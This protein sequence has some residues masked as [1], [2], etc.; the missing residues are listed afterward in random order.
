MVSAKETETEVIIEVAD[1]G[2][3]IAPDRLADITDPFARDQ[4][5]PYVTDAGWGLG[6]S[7]VKALKNSPFISIFLAALIVLC[8]F[9]CIVTCCFS[10][11]HCEQPQVACGCNCPNSERESE[12]LKRDVPSDCDCG[13]CFCRGAIIEAFH[14]TCFD[15]KKDLSLLVDWVSSD[16]SPSSRHVDGFDLAGKVLFNASAL[17]MRASLCSWQI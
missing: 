8:P 6:L 3:G 5:N 17:E 15:F 11:D 9:Q 12:P 2:V 7:I 4:S 16:C 13:D 1:T 10:S 14:A